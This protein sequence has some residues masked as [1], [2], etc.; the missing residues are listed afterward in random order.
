MLTQTDISMWQE[1]ERLARPTSFEVEDTFWGYIVRSGQRPPLGVVVSQVVSFFV[2]AC[3]LTAAVGMLIVPTLMLDAELAVLRL[4]VATVFA[5]FA[6][7]L[8][9]FASRGTRTELN[10]D[11]SLG[12]IREVIRNRAGGQTDI[13][14]YGFDAIGGIFLEL[15]EDTG[16][17]NLVLR[18]RNTARTIHVAEGT[19]AQ[20]IGL[21]D[22]LGLDLMVQPQ[23]L[24]SGR[25]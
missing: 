21:R 7:Y 5:A 22:R 3:F 2:G 17:S 20:L 9:W 8:L 12:E 24:T 1:Q 14:V 25:V 6:I 10:V 16:H 19:E 11:N 4:G 15:D 18:Y 13:G 23:T